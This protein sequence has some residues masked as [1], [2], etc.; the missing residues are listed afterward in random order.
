MKCQIPRLHSSIF[1]SFFFLL[2][3]SFVKS[4]STYLAVFSEKHFTFSAVNLRIML[5]INPF[6]VSVSILYNLKKPE[7]F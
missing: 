2:F 5:G 4:T 3:F 6:L 7:N 1:F